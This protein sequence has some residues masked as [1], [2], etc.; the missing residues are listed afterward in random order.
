MI[1]L[2]EAQEDDLQKLQYLDDEV[3]IDN[4]KYDNDLDMDWAKSE[5]GRQYFSDLLKDPN[6]Y[7]LLAQD[8]G[9]PIGYLVC[10]PKNV[11]YRKNKC[12]EI[13]NMGISPK[14]RSQG[15]GSMLIKKTLEWAKSEGYQKMYVSSYFDNQKAIMF[16]KKNGFLEIDL[17]LEQDL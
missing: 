11:N 14:Y 13:G 5:R 9:K 6:S 7:C 3:F 4:Q 17:G 12:V 8:N 10:L 16:Y 2:R 15:I 1:T